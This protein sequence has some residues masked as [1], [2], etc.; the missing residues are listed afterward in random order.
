[1]TVARFGPFRLDFER[2]ELTREGEVVPLGSRAFDILRVLVSA[3][4]DLVTK[5]ELM[6]QVWPGIA[7]EENNVQVHIS[8]LRACLSPINLRRL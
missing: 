6:A 1:M 7:V 3:K 4:G 2:R 8:S 5:D